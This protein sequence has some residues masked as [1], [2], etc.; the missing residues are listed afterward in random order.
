VS[1]V[2][3]NEDLVFA[4]VEFIREVT[5]AYGPER[6]QAIFEALGP[7]MGADVK[8][9]VFLAML[10]GEFE[11]LNVKFSLPIGFGTYR[12]VEAIKAIRS[13]N[14]MGLKEAKD[15][16][17]LAE[18]KEATTKCITREKAKE[19]RIALRDVGFS[20]R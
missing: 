18:W 11:T 17:E 14:G 10:T 12:K 16:A 13:A 5:R 19:L 1:N 15:L 3:D 8:G 4:G 2:N 7:A 9:A 6:G 20:V